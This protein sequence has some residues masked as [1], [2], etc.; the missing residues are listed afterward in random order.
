MATA[1]LLAAPVGV[2][3]LPGAW[4]DAPVPSPWWEWTS[5]WSDGGTPVSDADARSQDSAL[6]AEPDV[7][8]PRWDEVELAR[9]FVAGDEGALADVYARWSSMVYTMA[10]RALRDD[11]D[12]A[13]VTQNVFVSAWQGRGGYDPALGALGAWLVG[14]TRRRIADRW[15]AR[16]RDRRTWDAAVNAA[17]PDAAAAT[18]ADGVADRVLLADE[19]SRLGDPARRIIELAFFHDLTH[20]QI[21]SLLSLP[22]G[23]VKAHV[24][25][26][27]ARLRTRL[28]VD[29]AAL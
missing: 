8:D 3:S 24:R 16:Q 1:A 12:A 27:L 17:D 18:H 25:R 26:S 14:I 7:G 23:T 22:L 19:I 13:D 5:S 29:G 21:A 2:G 10:S 28:E 11:D 4:A 15:S 6:D 20:Q 9:R